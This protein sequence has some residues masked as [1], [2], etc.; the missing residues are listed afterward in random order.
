MRVQNI[1]G[2]SEYSSLTVEFAEVPSAPDAPVFVDRS[3]NTTDGQLPFITISWEVPSDV[4]GSQILGYRVEF[5]EGLGSY[6]T[7]YDGSSTPDVLSWKFEGLNA[8]SA[9]TFI[10][11]ARNSIGYSDA[12]AE[13]E[14]Y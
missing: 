10:V 6:S 14:I 2:Y 12:S 7:E 3:G 8:G 5:K 11:Y 1:I 4:G 9:Y 13:T